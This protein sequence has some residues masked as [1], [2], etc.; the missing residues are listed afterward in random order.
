[1]KALITADQI[2][3]R[4]AEN[5]LRFERLAMGG[6]LEAIVTERGGRVLGPFDPVSGGCLLWVNPVI[7][8]AGAFDAFLR[9]EEWNVGGDRVWIA[10]EIQFHVRDRSDFWNSLQLPPAV[11]PGNYRLT[12]A[13]AGEWRLSQEIH[14]DAFNLATGRKTLRLSRL[15]RAVENPLR[16]LSKFEEL[17]DG[18][19]YGGY[20]QAVTLAEQDADGIMAESWSLTQLNA[21]G[22]LLIPAA[23]EVE[24]TDY[25]E[26]IDDAHQT[27]AN[28]CV[29][30][31]ITGQRRYKVGYKAAQVL[32]RLGYFNAL[33][34]ARSYLLVR[35]F[36]NNPS[37]R[38]I[39]EPPEQAGCRGHSVHVYNDGGGFGGFGELEVNGQT[40]G[41]GADPET[42]TDQ[43]MLWFFVGET[44]RIKRIARN[45][46]GVMDNE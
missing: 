35:S 20:E 11:D 28:G 16:S 15:L 26:P 5:D 10:P 12:R 1:M 27:I 17:M 37:S 9:A 41:G 25:F 33:D 39:E 19:V 36:F 38:Y 42:R 14:L 18:V 43:F 31:R 24:H 22:D 8:D 32:G 3:G 45:L 29:R 34:E 44:G 46:L 7:G 13:G 40:L 2:A 4:L 23:G 30:L 21:G 6:G